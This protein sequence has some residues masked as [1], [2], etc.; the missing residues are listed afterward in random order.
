MTTEPLYIEATEQVDISKRIIHVDILEPNDMFILKIRNPYSG[1]IKQSEG[2]YLTTKKKDLDMH[3]LGL[4]SVENLLKANN[5]MMEITDE[6]GIF[7]VIVFIYG[8]SKL[9]T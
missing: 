6:G 2:K 3:S 7:Q 9:G 4:R 1:E 8:S 5:G